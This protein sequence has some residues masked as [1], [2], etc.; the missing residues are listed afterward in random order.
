MDEWAR[1]KDK[2][3]KDPLAANPPPMTVR[4]D[5]NVCPGRIQVFVNNITAYI[6]FTR[7]GP[8]ERIE[9]FAEEGEAT[10]HEVTAYEAGAGY[11]ARGYDRP[12]G[13]K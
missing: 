6:Q 12:P 2:M 13:N 9:Y 3:L 5:V 8:A 4:M 1:T 10:F 11:N 7:I